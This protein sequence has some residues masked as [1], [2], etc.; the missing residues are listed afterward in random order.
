M[1]TRTSGRIH[2]QTDEEPVQHNLQ[3]MHENAECEEQLQ[4]Q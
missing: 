3:S 2:E 1:E 4:E